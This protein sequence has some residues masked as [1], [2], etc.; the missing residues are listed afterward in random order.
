MTLKYNYN[1]LPLYGNERYFIT[2]RQCP[3][4]GLRGVVISYHSGVIVLSL[5]VI[6]I[7]DY[8]I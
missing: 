6:P 8:E 1:T 7:A 2:R 4:T 3:E 5:S